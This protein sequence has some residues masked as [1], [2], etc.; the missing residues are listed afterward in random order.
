M[1]FHALDAH[2]YGTPQLHKRPAVFFGD[3]HKHAA[4]ALLFSF[5]SHSTSEIDVATRC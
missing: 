2:T 4:L 3:T 1:I 5:P